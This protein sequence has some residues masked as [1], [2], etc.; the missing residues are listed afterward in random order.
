MF[1]LLEKTI[2]IDCFGELTGAIMTCIPYDGLNSPS[3]TSCVTDIIGGGN[4]CIP[5]I[6]WVADQLG[7]KTCN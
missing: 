7:I 3:M 1:F 2:C 5:C 4:K 6:C